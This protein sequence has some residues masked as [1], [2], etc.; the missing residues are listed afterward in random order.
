MTDQP[1][2]LSAAL[3]AASSPNHRADMPRP[4]TDPSAAL[5]EL[6]RIDLREHDLNQV[7]TRVA[8]LA[9]RTVTGADEVS[10][11]LLDGGTG[12]T[13]A[14]TGPLALESDERQ[15]QSGGPCVQAAET[16]EPV[17]VSDTATEDRWPDYV[18]AAVA[19]GVASSLSVPLPAREAVT[20]AINL[21]SRRPRAFDDD[22]ALSLGQSFAGYAGVAIANAHLYRTTAALARQMEAAMATRAVIE[23]AKGLLIGQHHCSPDEAFQ[24]L[25]RASTSSNRKLRDIA[26]DL[27]R[28]A[29]HP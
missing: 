1:F 16:G 4:P 21:Y 11:T 17:L 5:G 24:L 13:P 20:G 8:E 2:D 26:A 23:Q 12:T 18:P 25:V 3:R 14:F 15:Y 19:A 27:V 29:Q 22:E 9:Q 6:A 7:L 28:S 10:V